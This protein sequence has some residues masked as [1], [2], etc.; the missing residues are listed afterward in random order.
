MSGGGAPNAPPISAKRRMD[1]GYCVRGDGGRSTEAAHAIRIGSTVSRDT[2]EDLGRGPGVNGAEAA[3]TGM[4]WAPAAG[5]GGEGS[6]GIYVIGGYF[7]KVKQRFR[8]RE[9]RGRG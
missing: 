3:C 1:G 7:V 8:E 6:G 4:A 5:G 2:G 9:G